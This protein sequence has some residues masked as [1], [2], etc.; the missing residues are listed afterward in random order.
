LESET[1]TL[2]AELQWLR[3]HPVRLPPVAAS[4]VSMTTPAAEDVDYYTFD[5]LSSM[6]QST[7]KKF[8]WTKGEFK[9]VPYGYLWANMVYLSSRTASSGRSYT[10]WVYSDDTHGEDAFIVDGKTSRVGLAIVGPR[11]RL[12]NCAQSGGKLEIDFQGDFSKTANRGGVLLRHAYWEVKNPRFR[13]L[14][15]QTW[16]IVSPLV[17]GTIM[18]SVY[19]NAG[20]MGYRRAQFR[21]ERYFALSSTTLFTLQGSL[22]QNIFNDFPTDAT[23]RCEPGSWPLVEGRA[24]V[25]LG[26]RG[27]Y[28]KPIEVG[29]SGHIGEIGFDLFDAGGAI[30]VDDVRRRTWSINADFS[31]PI[32]DRFGVKGEFFTGEN[33]ST[34]LGGIGQG[35]NL[36]TTDTIRSTGGW[37]NL[38]YDWYGD[39]HTHVGYGLDDPFDG[40]ITVGRIYNQ[41]CFANLVYDVTDKF[42]MGLEVSSW[43][44][45]YATQRSGDSVRVEFMARYGF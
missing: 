34:F 18:Y 36:A 6:M 32:T 31:V 28:G 17:P 23:C 30:L 10:M 35:I 42:T 29:V 25:T 41:F 38:Y 8:A 14:A 20:N 45:L 3:E 22:N 2:R 21:A 33:L 13:L 11:L 16:D 9:V 4:Q 43:R 19:W 12:F 7:A 40:D 26:H 24:A 1:Q 37:F 44:T 15:G 27:K 39:L 5:E